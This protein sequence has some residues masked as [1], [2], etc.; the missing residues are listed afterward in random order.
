MRY[1]LGLQVLW[2]TL[3]AVIDF[4][5]N[6]AAMPPG[7]TVWVVYEALTLGVIGLAVSSGLWSVYRRLPRLHGVAVYAVAGAGAF[8]GSAA[9]FALVNL[10]DWA[11]A[12]PYYDPPLDYGAV[13]LFST[14]LLYFFTMLAWHT[15]ILALRAFAR[16][17]DAERLASEA[18]LLALRYQLNPHFLF[19]A[20]NS[21][22]AMID[23]DPKRAQTML[24][25]L[26]SLLR[27]TLQQ[28]AASMIALDQE[29]DMVGRYVE[30]EQVRFA[31]N[32]CVEN[33][34][35]DAARQCA[36][37]PLLVHALVENAIKH[38]MRTS[39]MPLKTALTATYEDDLL[40]I[41]VSNTGSLE[42]RGEGV[43][44]RNVADRLDALYPG[45]HRFSVDEHDAAVHAVVE[46]QAPEVLA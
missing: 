39:T 13:G 10:L 8:V 15:A 3:V 36:V 19:N 38:G 44:L 43:G 14:W 28:D 40:R 26:S 9:W 12:Y 42:P 35:S 46:I 25:M 34:V 17:A 37:P 4:L 16:A 22:I 32:L 6:R 31:D 45:R 41:E 7:S 18:R 11:L 27:Q 29:L 30:I 23:E 24:T 21:V 20:L 2:W 5:L 1:P 33:E